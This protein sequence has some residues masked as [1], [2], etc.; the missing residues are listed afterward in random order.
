MSLA[1]GG[2][3]QVPFGK[4]QVELSSAKHK[5]THLTPL[6]SPDCTGRPT[7]LRTRAFLKV[8]RYEPIRAPDGKGRGGLS[9]CGQYPSHRLRWLLNMDTA[10]SSRASRASPSNSAPRSL[11]RDSTNRRVSRICNLKIDGSEAPETLLNF[12][13]TLFAARELTGNRSRIAICY[14]QNS[15]WCGGP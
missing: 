2:F 15:L 11:N 1:T 7:S 4:G 14:L 6:S 8:L 12:C 3:H 13:Q 10:T 9:F 5:T